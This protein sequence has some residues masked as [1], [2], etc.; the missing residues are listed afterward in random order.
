[1]SPEFRQFFTTYYNH[2]K[3]EKVANHDM[4]DPSVP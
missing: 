2:I 3:R 1:M 4:A